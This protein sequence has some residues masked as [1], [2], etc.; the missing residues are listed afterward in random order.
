MGFNVL[1]NDAIGTIPVIGDIFSAWFKSNSRNLKLLNRWKAGD[2]E[3]VRRSGRIFLAVFAVVWL[4]QIFL[5]VLLWFTVLAA[6]YH[7]LGTA[8]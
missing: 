8:R 7:A 1:L 3:G 5:W 6:I 2:K 4:S